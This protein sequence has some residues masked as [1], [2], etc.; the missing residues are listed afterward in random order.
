LNDNISYIIRNFN[1]NEKDFIIY[2][3][4]YSHV[5]AL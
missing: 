5:V 4:Y 2:V 1:S 3:G